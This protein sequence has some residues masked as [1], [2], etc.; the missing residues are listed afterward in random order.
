MACDYA[1][2]AQIEE[3]L[4][5][6]REHALLNQ[7]EDSVV[8]YEG[9]LA[10]ISK[11]CRELLAEPIERQKFFDMRT[12]IVKERDNVKQILA[13]ISSFKAMKPMPKL[14]GPVRNSYSYE[15]RYD[16]HNQN[17]L[18]GPQHGA[19]NRN[20]NAPSAHE[21]A[22]S[23]YNQVRQNGPPRN[24]DPYAK[25]PD[26][27]DPLPNPPPQ[28]KAP[29]NR[30]NGNN[31]GNGRGN[32]QAS[33]PS[34][35]SAR[36]KSG[37]NKYDPKER[38]DISG[39]GKLREEAKEKKKEEKKFKSEFYDTELVDS[40]ER[41]VIDKSPNIKWEDIAGLK[42]PKDLLQEAVILPQVMPEYRD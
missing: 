3:N 39:L 32:N 9:A 10:K 35:R 22:K 4:K 8:Y 26:I 33:N 11:R 12:V 14:N 24:H 13:K 16:Q 17:N 27:W 41:E 34:S 40:L 7:Y 19:H 38:K 37:G 1:T 20:Y 42:I 18:H 30:G 29:S 6:A 31:R 28:A 23:Y 36:P 15:N 21:I 2:N 5:L 25:D